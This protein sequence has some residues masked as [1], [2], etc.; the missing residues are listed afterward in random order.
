MKLPI[1]ECLMQ[2][3]HALNECTLK[4]MDK[5]NKDFLEI[6]LRSSERETQEV[7]RIPNPK[8]LLGLL[9]HLALNPKE[10]VGLLTQTVT[11]E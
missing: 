8:E 6:Q 11:V 4:H 1:R 5:Y 10:L 3:S 7:K 2:K 9:T